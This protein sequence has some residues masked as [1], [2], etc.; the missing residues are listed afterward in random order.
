MIR[1]NIIR[2]GAAIAWDVTPGDFHTDDLEMAG[3][4]AA[5]VVR[6]GQMEGGYFLQHHMVFP[7]YRIFPNNTHGSYQTDIPEA[8]IP[9]HRLNG[10]IRAEC[11]RRVEIDGTLKLISDIADG[12]VSATVERVCYPSVDHAAGHQRITVTNTGEADIALDFDDFRSE[13]ACVLGPMGRILCEVHLNGEA[14]TLH[15][16][17][18][19][20]CYITFTARYGNETVDFGD[21]A[22]Q[23]D[24]RLARVAELISPLVLDTGNKVIDTFFRMAKIRAGESVF[25]TKYGLIHSPGGYNYYAATWC[26]DQVEYSGP[27]FA[28]TGD[29]SLLEAAMN[30]YRMY[31]PY[32]TPHY[33]PIPSS[34]IAEGLDFWSGAGDRGDAAMYLY[35]ASR[36]A[37]T[38]GRKEYAEELLPAIKWCAEYCRRKINDDGV[39]ASD[40]DELEN[41]FSSG[42]ANLC[43]SSLAY[44]G[45]LAAAHVMEG[46]GEDALAKEYRTLAN[47]L[48]QAIEKYFGTT[49]HGFE[50]YRYHEGC[51][52]LRAWICIPLYMGIFERVEGTVKA[53][54]SEYL[55]TPEGFLSCEGCPT[56]WDRAGLYGLCGIFSSGITEVAMEVFLRYT[57]VRLLGER[58]PYPVEAYPENGQRHLS[59]ESA[60][61]CKV[62]LEGILSITPTGTDRFTI[63]P[64]LPA[65]LDHLYLSDIHAFGGTFAVRLEKDGWQVIRS[66]GTVI[67]EG[68]YD[69]VAVEIRMG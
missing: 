10:V 63:K 49:L 1:W 65:A 25:N 62:I 5:Y 18:R 33:D 19:T 32:M 22:A 6:Y 11:L 3:F 45:Y 39:V 15:P 64:S 8:C 23:Y 21:P 9:H 36:F 28:Y 38:C 67:G 31:M 20:V 24:R 54:T 59:G 51:D 17:E 43:T 14:S 2:D 60:L 37:L 52:T 58:V 46:F 55:L 13:V 30:A 57:E 61:L 12:E 48:R 34:V 50:T 66:D 35:G 26:N 41:R 4:Y 69:G 40:C 42:D 16:G 27:Y 44:G 47:G 56:I 7:T 53:L 29:D 68:S